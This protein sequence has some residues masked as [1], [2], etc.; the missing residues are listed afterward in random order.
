MYLSNLDL[1]CDILIEEMNEEFFSL[2][3]DYF[4]AK[5]TVWNSSHNIK[6]KSYDVETYI[7]DAS[8]PHH[9]T[10]VYSIKHDSWIVKPVKAGAIDKKTLLKNTKK[11]YQSSGYP[12]K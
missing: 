3:K 1:E 7:Q 5:K 12:P 11:D 6:V 9:S 4:K 2:L 8:E 10:G